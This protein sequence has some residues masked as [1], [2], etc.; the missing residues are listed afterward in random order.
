MLDVEPVDAITYSPDE[1]ADLLAYVSIANGAEGTWERIPLE[2]TPFREIGSHDYV[3]GDLS[4]ITARTDKTIRIKVTSA[5]SKAL[6]LHAWAIG[7]K[8]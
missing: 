5:N 8:Y 6:K 3:R 4:G 1:S 2:A 7:V